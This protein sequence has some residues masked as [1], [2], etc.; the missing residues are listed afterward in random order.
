MSLRFKLQ[1]V[2]MADDN[3]VCIDDVVVLDKQ[4]ERLEHVGLSLGEAKT[5][6]V[7]LQRQVVTRQIAAF[8]TTR[9]ACPSCGRT[10]G[11]K[12]HKTVV[13]RALF[14]NL[15][16]PSPRLRRCP[17]QHDGQS[18]TSPLLELLPEHTAPEL[19]Y[20]ESKWSS[21]ASYGLTVQALHDFLPTDAKLSA[22]SVRRN[23][24]RVARRSESEI[25]ALRRRRSAGPR[26]RGTTC[27][28]SW[29][30]TA[31]ISVTGSTSRP[32]SWQSSASLSRAAVSP[33][34]SALFRART[35]GL[36][37]V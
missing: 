1:L 10:R 33:D 27:R 12:D 11:I 26:G 3:E 28:V 19:V 8:L 18:S 24:L 31:G 22:T 16:L 20:L 29:A 14:G 25:C 9:A 2:V 13:F 21:L 6:L 37:A 32:I 30:S 5:L 36:A 35:P 15:Q 4:H 34:A 23:T 17:C 7:E